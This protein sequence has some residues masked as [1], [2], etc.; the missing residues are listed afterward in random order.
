M[1]KPRILLVSYLYPPYA[2]IG[3][4]RIGKLSRFLMERGWDVRVLAADSGEAKNLPVEI[5]EERVVYTPWF[6]VDHAIDSLIP[7]WYRRRARAAATPAAADALGGAS[8]GATGGGGAESRLRVALRRLYCELVRW[9]DNRIG[10]LPHAV[11]AGSTLLADW[12]PDIIYASAPPF[13]S[14]LVADRLARRF[15]I[16]WIAEFRDLWIDHPYYSYSAARKVLERI[17]EGRVLDRAA[18]MVTVSPPWQ[19]VLRRKFGKPTA[20]IMNGFVLEDFPE[21]PPARPSAEGPVRIVYTGHIYEGYRDPTPLFQ[22]IGLLGEERGRVRV[23]F[24]GTS[25]EVVRALARRCGV[26]DL[27][28]VSPPIPYREALRLQMNA[29]VLLHLQWND[30]RE[31]G[32]I[33]GK[34][35]EYIAARRPVLGI[36]YDGGSVA[37][38]MREHGAGI[39]CNEAEGI[40]RQLRTWIAEKASGGIAPLPERSPQGLSRAEQFASL[41]RF[42]NELRPSLRRDP[43]P[44]RD[45]TGMTRS[46]FHAPIDA[47]ALERPALVAIVDTEEDFDWRQPF[48]RENFSVSS[49]GNLSLAQD[50]FQRWNIVPTYLVDYPVVTSDM[51]QALLGAWSREGRCLVGAQ[52]HPWVNPPH[53]E[54]V[55][56]ANSFAGN[57]P[58][59]LERA[60]L[61]ALTEEIQARIGVRPKVYKAGRY[62]LGPN[63]AEILEDLGYLVDT[64]IM[65]HTDLSAEGGPDYSGFGATPFWFGQ[66][67]RL[68]SLPVSRGFAGSLAWAGPRIF[69]RLDRSALTRYAI[70]GPFARLHAMERITLTPEGITFD[71]LRRLTESL[72][73]GG[74]RVI[75]FSFHS[76]SLSPGNTPYVRTERDLKEFITTTERYFRYFLETIGGVAMTPIALYE[77]LSGEAA[78]VPSGGANRVS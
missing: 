52:L 8:S 24:V 44:R 48:S 65:P 57:L 78:P 60:K 16:P 11:R 40:A 15:S 26:E 67:R 7:D 1:Q 39:V 76:P 27:V 34:L 31:E 45:Q 77:R 22:A 29:D 25:N 10:W 53:Q 13:T 71:E 6:E 2:G 66:H 20:L 12:R 28:Q 61:A 23:E 37:Q 4:L 75:T 59:A 38:I 43:Q 64:S 9:P 36:G 58:R 46:R 18:A 50:V 32:T 72:L 68:L 69:P 41:E 56:K 47:A 49:L 62:G 73:A 51:G 30:P 14:L 17:W 54:T 33:S 63:S 55:S 5:P 70:L 19:G 21:M 35:F 42:L 74:Q 3:A